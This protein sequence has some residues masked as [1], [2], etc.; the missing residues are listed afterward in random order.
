M[1]GTERTFIMIKPDGVQRGQMGQII[2][3]FETRGYKLLALL[4]RSP[5]KALLESHYADLASKKFF[6]G[7]IE[8]MLSGPVCTMVWAGDN[9]VLTGRKLLGA[10]KPS[11]SNC[12]TI[13]GNGCIDV[14]RNVRNR[15][16]CCDTSQLKHFGRPRRCRCCSCDVCLTSSF[17]LPPFSC[18]MISLAGVPRFGLRRECR[19]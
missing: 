14:G 18:P 6:P 1:S 9:V 3:K 4:V 5:T 15:A 10:T 13:R 17:P 16:S 7:L 12:G 19:A 8:Y 2:Q 11:D